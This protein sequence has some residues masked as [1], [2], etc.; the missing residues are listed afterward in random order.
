MSL[1]ESGSGLF[2]QRIRMVVIA[3]S[4]TPV[5][6]EARFMKTTSTLKIVKLAIL[7]ACLLPCTAVP[8]GAG[9]PH[10]NIEWCDVWMPHTTDTGLPRVLMIGDSIT[11][12]YFPA[13]EKLL[14]GKAFCCRI[15][16]SRCVGDP[17]LIEEIAAF[18]H[19]QPFDVVHFNNGMH[20]WANS[21]E[22]YSKAFPSL[23]EALKKAAPGAKLI[24]ANTTAV[25]K[26]CKNTDN[27]RIAERN[28]LAR[29]C[30]S[31]LGIP[32]DD[33]FTL[34]VAHPELHSDS[35]HFNATGVDAQAAQVAREIE[36]LLPK[37]E[38]K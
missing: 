21:E 29:E 32:V 6:L 12:G 8:Q 35:V 7:A 38:R 20:G 25:R 33:L 34:T 19:R 24:W 27:Q 31:K 28:R 5:I 10:E 18:A 26:D 30:V 17:A 36:K 9:V 16:T 2:A 13:V 3:F 15:A 23:V 1:N 4:L 11:R 14:A 22:V 37:T